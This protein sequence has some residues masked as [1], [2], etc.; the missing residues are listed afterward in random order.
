VPATVE[1]AV[2]QVNQVVVASINIQ[3][4]VVIPMNINKQSEVIAAANAFN[5]PS[6]LPI[7]MPIMLDIRQLLIDQN[8]QY[9]QEIQKTKLYWKLSRNGFFDL[10]E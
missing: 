3:N 2:T 5:M 7:A 4:N 1:Q 8:K 9:I 10:S 6:T